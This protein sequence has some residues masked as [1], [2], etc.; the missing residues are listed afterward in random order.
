MKNT[1]ELVYFIKDNIN[2]Q[3]NNFKIKNNEIDD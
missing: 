1:K 3:E 2:E